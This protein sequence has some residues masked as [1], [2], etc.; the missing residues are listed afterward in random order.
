MMF[1][2]PDSLHLWINVFFVLA[3]VAVAFAFVALTLGVRDLRRPAP[4]PTAVPAARRPVEVH[5]APARHAA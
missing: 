3:G 4:S 2:D 1:H 5:G